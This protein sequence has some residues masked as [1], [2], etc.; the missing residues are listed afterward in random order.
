MNV[1]SGAEA[2]Q[3]PEKEFING[4]FV[5]VCHAIPDHCHGK[6]LLNWKLLAIP[7][8]VDA[9]VLL[10][11]HKSSTAPKSR[12]V[13]TGQP[14]MFRLHLLGYND[15]T[16]GLLISLIYGLFSSTLTLLF[17]EPWT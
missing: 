14:S 3:F 1:E 17:K 5:A 9:E 12:P 15:N 4:I 6:E 13:G 7:T 16:T 10:N 11:V 2:A 8:S